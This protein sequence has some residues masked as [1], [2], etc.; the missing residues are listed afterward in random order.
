MEGELRGRAGIRDARVAVGEDGGL[1]VLGGLAV[2]H[3]HAELVVVPALLLVLQLVVLEF[4]ECDFLV[5]FT[6]HAKYKCLLLY[7]YICC[8]NIRHTTHLLLFVDF[9]F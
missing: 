2:E 5:A 7:K 8:Y 9:S 3:G 1:G 4:P 6:I